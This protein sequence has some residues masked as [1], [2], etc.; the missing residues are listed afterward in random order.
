MQ[1]LFIALHLNLPAL[2]NYFPNRE[3]LVLVI[4]Q[5]LVQ[6]W[7]ADFN[8]SLVAASYPL[9]RDAFNRL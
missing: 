3:A 1:D 7:L 4:Y 8:R 5:R 6:R 9:P 2:Y